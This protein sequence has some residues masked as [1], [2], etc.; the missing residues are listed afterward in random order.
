MLKARKGQGATEYLTI[1]A[2][3]LVIA[4]VAI[5]LMGF[6]PGL[7]GDSKMAQSSSYWRLATPFGITETKLSGGTLE[8]VV[9]SNSPEVLALSA[10]GLSNGTG[11]LSGT[12]GASNFNPGA[13]TIV[14]FANAYSCN[15]GELV[16][17]TT[18]T[19]N[20]SSP[21]FSGLQQLGQRDLSVK[22]S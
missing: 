14:A 8:V 4:I 3:V 17:F 7:T 13:S 12:Y 22:C 18:V 20:Y 2:V 15:S 6:F 1:L 5:V 9:Q 11:A 16:T 19:F 10:M 21:A